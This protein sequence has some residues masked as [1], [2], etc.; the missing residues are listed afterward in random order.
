LPCTVICQ[1]RQV[2]LIDHELAAIGSAN[3]DNRSLRLNFEV[4]R[5]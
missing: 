4:M 5:G 3:L 2:L 1:L